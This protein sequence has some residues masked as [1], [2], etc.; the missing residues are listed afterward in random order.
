MPDDVRDL[1]RLAMAVGI[2]TRQ[3]VQPARNVAAQE[4]R[5]MLES[6]PQAGLYKILAGD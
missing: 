3:V 6:T 5:E 4:A 1:I 2:A